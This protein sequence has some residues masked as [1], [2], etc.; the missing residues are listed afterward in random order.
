MVAASSGFRKDTRFALM[1]TRIPG[2]THVS[3]PNGSSTRK[4]AAS[5]AFNSYFSHLTMDTSAMLHPS[6]FRLNFLCLSGF[7]R[8]KMKGKEA[9]AYS[10]LKKHFIKI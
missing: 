6:P 9:Y 5:A 1:T 2:F 8:K 3:P 10:I 7:Q 4:S